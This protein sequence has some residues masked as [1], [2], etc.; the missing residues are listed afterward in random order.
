VARG[1]VDSAGRFT[2][3]LPLAAGA[4]YRAVVT[5]GHGYSP[6]VSAPFTPSS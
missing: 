6:G 1:A 2:I 4:T 3:S 5:S